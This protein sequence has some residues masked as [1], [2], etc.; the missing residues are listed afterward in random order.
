MRIVAYCVTCLSLLGV[1]RLI[2]L[3]LSAFSFLLVAILTCFCDVPCDSH[4]LQP[5][6]AVL[7]HVPVR[8]QAVYLPNKLDFPY[9]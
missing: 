7:Q 6:M 9:L 8:S 4:C 5:W 2:I 1:K 3:R